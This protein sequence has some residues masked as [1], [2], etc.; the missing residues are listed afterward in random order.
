MRVNILLTGK[1]VAISLPY[2]DFLKLISG[3][4]HCRG[5]LYSK[6]FVKKAKELLITAVTLSF[7]PKLTQP[8]RLFL[9]S[10]TQGLQCCLTIRG[11][12]RVH[13][14]TQQTPLSRDRAAALAVTQRDISSL[15]TVMVMSLAVQNSC[16]PTLC[17]TP[18][19]Q[20]HTLSTIRDKCPSN[21][22]APWDTG[23][24]APAQP[25]P[26]L[27][28][29]PS[30]E[31]ACSTDLCLFLNTVLFV[32]VLTPYDLSWPCFL[33]ITA[34]EKKVFTCFV[35]VQT[36]KLCLLLERCL[37]YINEVLF[38]KWLTD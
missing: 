18:G 9:H 6:V 5:I 14:V 13:Q 31:L 29:V 27:Q 8:C 22:S 38:Q 21:S 2:K 10:H 24:T 3:G 11:S 17:P 7:W 37:I 35:Y 20:A 12:T 1:L 4:K 15:L 25:E 32:L 26:C 34:T 33:F 16:G 30:V 19:L 36:L 23:T 28:V